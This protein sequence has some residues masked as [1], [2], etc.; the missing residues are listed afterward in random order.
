[1]NLS[2]YLAAS[3]FETKSEFIM[4]T[5]IAIVSTVLMIF[6][7]YRL[8]QMLQLTGY[9][10][11]SYLKWFKETKCSYVSR[12]FM[13]AF[14]SF[15]SMILTNVLL[16]DFFVGKM[17]IFSYI[18]IL[19]YLLF[20]S[21]FIVNMFNSKQKTPLK[22]TKRMIRLV[23]V[24]TIIV[25]FATFGIEYLGFRFFPFISFGLISVVPLILPLAVFLAYF[26]TYPLER[27]I[28]KSYIKRAKK[29]LEEKK[30]LKIIGITGSYGKTS[31]KNILSTILS[32][33]FKICPTP[34]SYNTPL[35]LAKTILSNLSDEDEIFIAEMG[36]KQ[37]G[38]IT[39]LCEMVSPDIG[40]I[41][42]IGNQHYLTFGSVENIVKTKSELAEF[43]TNKKGKLFVNTD[44]SL[45]KEISEKFKDS[46]AVSI[47]KN[48]FNVSKIETSKNGSSFE[49]S[50]NGEKKKCK[51]ILLGKHNIS[52]IILSATVA[53]ELGLSLDEIIQ[54]IEKLHSVS[55]R[56]EIIKSTSS[57][58]IIDNS[59]NS[60][61]QGSEASIEVLSKFEGRKF[62]ITPG[63]V[64]LGKEQFNSNFEFGRTMA[65]VCDY[66]IIDSTINY[67]AINAGLVSEGFDK[68]HILR[69]G[70][71][72]QAVMVLNTLVQPEDVVLFENDLPDN[73]S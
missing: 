51:T 23:V 43:V 48:M 5:I 11:K 49:I 52:N 30:N 3:I 21:L 50:F 56:L 45:A 16:E 57:Y 46:V 6:V 73:Y 36:A 33:K 7:G 25:G 31:V 39:E 54:G 1:M 35:G 61:V 66:V 12:L 44:G 17:Q 2:M 28:S 41:T 8:L 37:V 13:L 38:D 70:N 24:Y 40:V 59:Y 15:L 32:V 29:K 68:E 10:F 26:I 64:E 60:S 67:E 69:A 62:V 19:G 72:S 22:Y 4:F 63:L 34:A 47:E 53:L 9:K 58:T 14:L 65:K 42:G 20:S 71:L 55:H 27:L 18:S